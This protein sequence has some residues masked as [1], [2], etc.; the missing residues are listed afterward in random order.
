ERRIGLLFAS[1]LLLFVVAITR[2]AWVQGIQAGTLSAD[3][4]SQHSQTVTVFGQRGSILD[5]RGRE[6][7]VSE[8]AADVIATPYQVKDPARA[9]RRLGPLLQIPDAQILRALADRSSGFAY[10]ARQVDLATADKVRKLG[11]GGISTVPSQRRIYPEG[12]LAAQVIGT[13]GID[14]QGLTGLEAGDNDLLGGANG[15]RKVTFDGLGKEIERQTLSGAQQGEDLRLT[16]DAGL[17]ARTEE[18][19]SGV[20][21]TYAPKRATA[22]VMNPRSGDVLAMADW[23]TIDPSNPS[24]ADPQDLQNMATGFTYEPGSTFKAFTVAGALEEHLVTPSTPFELPTEIQVA[25]RTISDAEPRGPET[26]TVAQILAQS[27]NVGAVKIG[28]ELGA[29]RFYDWVRRFGFGDPTGVE[30]PGEERGIVPTPSQFSG[31]TMGNLPIGQ[32]LSVTPI[33][34]AAAYAAIA[35]GGI[36]RAPRLVMDQ[37]DTP[38]PEPA[39]RRVISPQTAA[40]LRQ[41]LEGVLAPGGTA[42]EV[43]VPGYTLAGKTGTAQVAVNGTYSNSRYVASFVGFAPAANPRLLVAVVVD[44][45]QQ[46]SYYGGTV[47][48]PAFGEIA[49]FALPYLHIPPDQNAQTAP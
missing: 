39:G 24:A 26:L 37:G 28:L 21:R 40:Q 25:D 19:L 43:S 23:P 42:S 49:R 45:P 12:K 6:L 34:M 22:I 5:R 35:N 30:Y 3:A 47:A 2:A 11:I 9:S 16:I 48:A 14:D 33:Q 27:S 36:L 18:V 10:L 13:V 1:F 8:D 31:S 44:E 46:G 4:Q 38:V 7:A 29:Q 20:A 41:M 15:E 17:Q 32:G